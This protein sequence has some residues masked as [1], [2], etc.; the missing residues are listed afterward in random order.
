MANAYPALPQWVGTLYNPRFGIQERIATNG[1][2]RLR[3][4]QSAAKYDITLYHGMLTQTQRDTLVTF[5]NAN[6]LLTITVTPVEDGVLR[7]CVFAAQG[8]KIEPL[9]SGLYR[10]TVYLRQV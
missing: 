1:A 6:R 4:L 2:V 7:T 5:Y 10:A 3:V 8:Y 9:D